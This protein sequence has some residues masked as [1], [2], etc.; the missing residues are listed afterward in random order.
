MDHTEDLPTQSVNNEIPPISFNTTTPTINLTSEEEVLVDLLT[1]LP[2]EPGVAH[3]PPPLSRNASAAYFGEDL[4]M[5][6]QEAEAQ[7]ATEEEGSRRPRAPPLLHR[8][9]HFPPPITR[10]SHA[11]VFPLMS[12]RQ[13][14]ELCTK[15]R[16]YE[17]TL[18]RGDARETFTLAI[19]EGKKKPVKTSEAPFSYTITLNEHTER[20]TSEDGIVLIGTGQKADPERSVPEMRVDLKL[21]AGFSRLQCMVWFAEGKL[22]IYDP[23]SLNGVLVQ[24]ATTT[25]R[26]VPMYRK[27]AIIDADEYAQLYVAQGSKAPIVTIN[28]ESKQPLNK[29]RG[30][31]KDDLCPICMENKQEVVF[32]CGHWIG[33][34]VRT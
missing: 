2:S 17:A 20:F 5:Q 16:H 7:A 4:R 25:V 22:Y 34:N 32:N 1:S 26:S 15:R 8:S 27:C 29:K 21:P 6:V 24:T 3:P 23:G 11:E 9:D 30:R 18:T 33:C 14:N 10:S 19:K 28:K 31:E 12:V 13:S